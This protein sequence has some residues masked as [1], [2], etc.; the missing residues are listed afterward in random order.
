MSLE[1]RRKLVDVELAWSSAKK[2]RLSILK[3]CEV[4]DIR[5]SG[6]YYTATPTDEEDLRMPIIAK[7]V[8]AHPAR[9]SSPDR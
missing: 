8:R 3:Q 5:R 9:Y 7:A 4:L 6:F 1:E 2:E